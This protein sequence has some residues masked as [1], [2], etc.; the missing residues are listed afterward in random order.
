M[1][2]KLADV[3]LYL[4]ATDDKLK[5]DLRSAENLTTG[6]GRNVSG[7]MDDVFRG[8][9]ERVGQMATNMVVNG[10]R[11]AAGLVVDSVNAA[12]DLGESIN[13]VNVVFDTS[14]GVIQKWS[15]G[16]ATALGQSRQ[17]ALEAVGTFGNLFDSM[18]ITSEKTAEMSTSL[19]ELASDLASFNNIDPAI[20][21]EKLRAGVVG[22]VEPLR[23][24]GVNLTAVA[25]KAKALQLGIVETAVDQ[26]KWQGAFQDYNDALLEQADA[27]GKN[28][29]S[30]REY[31]R[32]SQKVAETHERL[33]KV[34]EGKVP[35]LTAAQKAE[36]AYALILEQTANA[37]GD[38]ANTADGAAN[39]QRILDAQMKDMKATLGGAF[40]PA[41]TELLAAMNAILKDAMPQIAAFVQ[42][43]LGPAVLEFVATVKE[44]V[45]W[46]MALD[47]ATQGLI[48]KIAGF[49]AL[50]VPLLGILAPVIGAVSGLV[51]IFGAIIPVIGTVGGALAILL[52]PIGLIVAAVIGLTVAWSQNW[53]GIQDITNTV[54]SAIGATLSQWWSDF[55]LGASTALDNVK[56]FWEQHDQDVQAIAT[57]HWETVGLLWTT[58]WDLLK[59]IGTAGVQFLTGDWQGGMDTLRETA[60]TFWENTK[61]LFQTQLDQVKNLFTLFGW[62]DLGAQIVTGIA[63][64]IKNAASF[65]ADALRGAAQTAFNATADWLRIGSPSRRAADE[66]GRP[67]AEGFGVGIE[68]SMVKVADN[69]RGSVADA[70]DVIT[71]DAVDAVTKYSAA[72]IDSN[73]Y[74]NDWLTD[75]PDQI[76]D[77]VK[78]IGQ[79]ITATRESGDYLND[80]L[81]TIPET[82]REMVKQAGQMVTLFNNYGG[83]DINQTLTDITSGLFSQLGYSAPMASAP[84]MV[85]SGARP[86]GQGRSASMMAP[87]TIT[88]NFY[89][90]A[91]AT[92]VKGAAEAGIVSAMRS[93]GLR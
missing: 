48:A 86:G 35:E 20:A 4:G 6:W 53:F 57:T 64:G 18:G 44:W 14:A 78:N 36:A 11:A 67:V 70:I 23:T 82:M 69:V 65:M 45:S 56:G 59:G 90:P 32:A 91:D 93:L 83:V 27:L 34:L 75:V 8:A 42:G 77:V 2:I 17:Q 16:A 29:E 74:L 55:K 88:Q 63:N 54:T 66:L 73:D 79:Y 47:P 12:G 15:E 28:G 13:K 84:A 22:E 87:I 72:V 37:Q 68:E 89:G 81:M 30:S 25:V 49:T 24:L 41:W 40:I 26:V 9:F 85:P 51:G 43:T 38:F 5:A 7:R 39:A 31:A 46:F 19:V 76:R 3:L 50:L 71:K 62:G 80:W 1:A 58:Q 61:A 60:G 92:T 10:A 21:L 33:N 52:N